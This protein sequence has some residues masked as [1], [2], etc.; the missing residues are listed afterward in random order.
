MR[1]TLTA[2]KD[3]TGASALEFAVVAPLLILLLI[4]M[5]EFGWVFQNQLAITHA[6]R[7]GA[8]L[9]AVNDGANWDPGV[10]ESRAYPLTTADGLGISL[11]EGAESVTVSVTYPYDWQLLPFPGTLG[12]ESTAVMRKE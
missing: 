3:S 9:A 2:I 12:L 5:I 10:V 8:R 1:R 7:E 6:A 4:G 11:S